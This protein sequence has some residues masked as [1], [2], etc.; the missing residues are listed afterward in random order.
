MGWLT[1][2]LAGAM[3]GAAKPERKAPPRSSGPVPLAGDDS[4]SQEVVAESFYQ[5]A[6]DAI[7]GGKCEDGHERECRAVLKPEPNNKHD[8]NA[9]AVVIEGATVAY[10]DRA[11][12]IEFHSA[13]RALGAPGSAA[14]C[15]A[16]INGGWLRPRAR[17][18]PDE[19]HYGVELDLVWPLRT[20]SST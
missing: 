9:V 4:F 11:M 5:D 13:M 3:S 1:R 15:A 8:S 18:K 17:G 2:M 14:S 19:G 20:A 10:L 12:A 16:I 6:L 7:C